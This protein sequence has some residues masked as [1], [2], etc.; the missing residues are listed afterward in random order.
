MVVC[1]VRTRQHTKYQPCTI[2]NLLS[3]LLFT[4]EHSGTRRR[5]QRTK[6]CFSTLKASLSMRPVQL[7]S[8][9]SRVHCRNFFAGCTD[10]L[11]KASSFQVTFHSL[12]PDSKYGS[13]CKENGSR[14]W[15]LG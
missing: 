2:R 7:V 5:T 12:S 14:C 8:L 3:A 11:S 10:Q 13:R 4:G 6:L 9:T 1:P 15:E